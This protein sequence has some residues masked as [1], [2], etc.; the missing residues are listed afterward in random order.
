V[1][2]GVM[3]KR[4]KPRGDFDS[5]WKEALEYLLSHF[6][7]FFYPHIYADI[8]WSKAYESLDKELHQ[9]ARDA[10]LP[11]GL[12]DKLFKVWLKEGGEAWLLI[13]V[14]IQGTPEQTFPRRMFVYNIRA[15]DRYGKDVVSLAVL[16][17]EQPDWHPDHFE[18]GR[19]GGSTRLGFLPVKLLDYRG[20]EAVLERDN[21]PFAQVVL[22][23]LNSLATKDDLD[24]RERYKLRLVKGL[25]QRGWTAEDVRQLFRLIDWIMDL[26]PE[27]QRD[28]RERIFEWE[29]EQRMPY[30][31]SIERLA[32]E[33]AR[34]E[35]LQETIATTLKIRFGTPGKRLVARVRKISDLNQ[36]QA[37]FRTILKTDSLTEVRQKL[38]D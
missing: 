26:P 4:K 31:T 38:T 35:T 17:D 1:M 18:Y 14:E 23:H 21:N 6:L 37:L 32:R 9:I 5:P 29:E 16:T 22:A 3:G 36:L 7:A 19:W 20:R 12:A 30:V 2:T 25:Y 15:F 11:K 34:L 8:D 13:H 24:G 27:L 10:R 33:E 28:F